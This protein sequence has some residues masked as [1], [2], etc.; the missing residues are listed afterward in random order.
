MRWNRVV[1]FYDAHFPKYCTRGIDLASLR[2]DFNSSDLGT[3]L[4]LY[5]IVDSEVVRNCSCCLDKSYQIF[6]TNQE[7]LNATLKAFKCICYFW[8]NCLRVHDIPIDK[9]K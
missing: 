1:T 3:I 5:F 7:H 4:L 9:S 8:T 6:I 2:R